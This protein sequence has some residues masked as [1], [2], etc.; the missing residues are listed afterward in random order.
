ME[1]SDRRAKASLVNNEPLAP[2]RRCGRIETSNVAGLISRALDFCFLA[3]LFEE[4]DHADADDGRELGD[5]GS[6]VSG[7]TLAPRRQRP[8]RPSVPR[9]A[10]LL[11]AAQHQLAGAPGRVR[12]LEFRLEALLAPQP[13]RRV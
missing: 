5:G 8:E 10:P 13:S 11:H 2:T 12:E 9:S 1:A 7:R 4:A 6:G 3:G